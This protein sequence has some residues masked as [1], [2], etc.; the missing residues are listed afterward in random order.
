MN[1]ELVVT[2]ISTKVAHLGGIQSTGRVQVGD[3]VTAVS[4]NG[5]E[6]LYLALGPQRMQHEHV[7]C[8]YST[9]KN[10]EEQIRIQVERFEEKVQLF[11][12]NQL[13]TE[14]EGDEK[15]IFNIHALFK[16]SEQIKSIYSNQTF[17]Y[18]G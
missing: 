2:K 7:S 8:A 9:L 10:A 4:I 17:Y 13:N 1:A 6:S 12:N 18:V 14:R 3:A 16:Q 15:K 5:E 11:C